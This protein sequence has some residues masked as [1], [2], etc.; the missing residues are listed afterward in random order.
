VVLTLHATD[1]SPHPREVLLASI[2]V[3]LSRCDR[4][5]VHKVLD[6]NRMKDLG[7]VENVTLFPHGVLPMVEAP[8]PRKQP[9]IKPFI[10]GSYGFFLPNKGLPELVNAVS[11]LRADGRNIRLRMINA[12]YPVVESR[13]EIEEVK[14]Q[15]ASLALGDA[16]EM[17][18]GFLP[19]KVALS[20][21][22]DCDLIVFGYQHS[23]ESAS[24]AVRYG[25]ISGRPVAVTPLEIFSDVA[26]YCIQLPGTSAAE[27]AHGI[28]GVMDR[29][30]GEDWRD[31]D[32][33]LEDMLVRSR[34]Y[35]SA[36]SYAVLGPRL[37]G[38]LTALW[39]DQQ[40][41]L[42]NKSL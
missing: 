12:E 24:G 16:I 2:R 31:L 13:N 22:S 38:M 1:D 21:L 17:D 26:D 25:L 33:E 30:G 19:D 9:K 8:A 5:L 4:I 18:T 35:V 3:A 14:D 10:I 23:S 41:G 40:N 20:K 36:R 11:Y 15:I 39:D 6:A 7:L 42:H 29:M 32:A 27:M 37:K 28:A 34:A